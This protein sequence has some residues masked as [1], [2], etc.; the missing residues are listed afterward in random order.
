MGSVQI[1]PYFPEP[2]EVAGNVAAERYLVTLGFVLRTMAGHFL[3]VC[4]AAV[5][6]V[7]APPIV[8]LGVATAVFFASLLALTVL[9]RLLHGRMLDNLLSTLLMIPTLWSL[10]TVLRHL[11]DSGHPVWIVGAAYLLASA[12]ALFCG[13]DFSFVGQFMLTGMA[14]VAVV[15]AAVLAGAVGWAQGLEWLGLALVFVFYYVYDLAALLSRRRLREEPA[16]VADLYRDLLNFLTYSVRI[17]L[18]WRR[19]RFL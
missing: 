8:G 14:S 15:G 3:S 10:G 2:I 11:H 9:R 1:Q 19:F 16:A 6:A 13:S 17:V 4:A 12:Y 7:V 5:V 18:H